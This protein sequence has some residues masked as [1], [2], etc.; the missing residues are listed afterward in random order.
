MPDAIER[1]LAQMQKNPGASE[2]SLRDLVEK[3]WIALP[4]W[5]LNLLRTSNG[6]E[7]D[8]GSSYLELWSAEDV[9]TQNIGYCTQ[10]FHPGMLLFGSSMGGV[11]YAFDGRGGK[12][13]IVEIPFDSTDPADM[14]HRGDTVDEF[15]SFLVSQ[16]SNND[17]M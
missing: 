8:V 17:E 12:S 4:E 3:S 7:G 6:A 1:L 15:L 5:Y 9:I 11:A 13:S 16:F 10:E 2:A 14:I